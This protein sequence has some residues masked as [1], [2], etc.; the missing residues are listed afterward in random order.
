MKF[1]TVK[2][3]ILIVL[4][5]ISI[6]LSYTL[7]SYQPNSN[8]TISSEF[9][10]SEID[11]GGS[12][13]ETKRSLIKP[14]DIIFHTDA[15]YFGFQD[16]K[17]KDQMFHQMQDWVISNYE[18]LDSEEATERSPEKIELIFADEIPM[19]VLGTLFNF[20]SDDIIFPNWSMKRIYISFIHDSKSLQLEF[21]SD[22]SDQR[23]VALINDAE[24]YD[25]LW[26]N[27]ETLDKET[28]QEYLV[29]NE[30]TNP[31]YIPAGKI[32]MD[33][34]SITPTQIQPALFVNILFT[35]PAVVRET[36]SQTIGEAYFTDN[37][38]MSVYQNGKR[39][40]YISHI[41]PSTD[42][43]DRVISELDLL[44]RSINNINNHSGWT[45]A[46]RLNQD[47]RLDDVNLNNNQVTYQMYYKSYPVFNIHK[48]ATIQQRWGNYQNGMQL[49]EYD[50]PLYLFDSEF[51]LRE[52]ELPSGENIIDLLESDV[53]VTME[54]IED[55]KIGYE[56]KYQQDEQ[57]SEYFEMVPAWY[58]KENNSWQKIIFDEEKQPMGGN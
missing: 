6:L 18:V 33:S 5:G 10:N 56:L 45:Y 58:K 12:N 54:N 15:G 43:P 53:D 34:Y 17:S 4:I 31:V 13:D 47:Y 11:A 24:I 7:W 55:V 37:R 40:E 36:N 20:G 2:T 38:Q 26:R 50:R 16:S 57:D 49:I 8:Q 28:Y 30:Q 51:K 23:A 35:N 39:M 21:S 42:E 22:T 19:K 25:Q 32:K 44:D 9:V 52:N 1:E 27:T 41:S 29:I 14:V 48:L 3:F 46:S